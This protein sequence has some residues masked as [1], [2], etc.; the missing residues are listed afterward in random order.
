MN[1]SHIIGID[2]GKNSFHLV[3]H[4]HA[5]NQLFKKKLTRQKLLEFLSCHE[6]VI[7]AMESCGGSHWLARK[8]T[9]FGHTAKLIPPQYVKPYVKT[10]K[11]DFI[12][13]NAIAEAA[14]R[15]TMRFSSA[16]T[17]S[18]QVISAI[19]KIRSGYIRERTACMNR[20]GSILLEF[21]IS[22][23]K[24][25]ASMKGLFQW[26]VDKN[27]NLPPLIIFELSELHE[28]YQN[29][30]ERID[31][32]ADKVERI[33]ADN[34]Q[35][36][37]LQSVPGIGPV[38]ASA[39]LSSVGNPSDFKNGRNFAA[40]I[41]LVPIQYSTGG[42]ST[43]LGISKRGNKELRTLFIHATRSILWR[44]K[45][46]EKYFGSWLVELKKR[47][48]FNVAVVALANKIARIAWAVLV[49]KKSF[50]IRT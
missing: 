45:S 4:D 39:C 46:V 42:K 2:L 21:G 1:N 15:P 27:Q 3:G 47:K 5:G 22:L 12:D 30:N 14:S 23:P 33:L 18:A 48:P 7:I 32:Q 50:E 19:R 16:K 31:S 26:L 41:G 8:C 13:A 9:E 36:K 38:I 49:S 25:H 37:Q 10:N 24:G 34:E 28:H 35:M 17:E 29:L 44:D 43:L 20:I 40:W 11:N 6:P